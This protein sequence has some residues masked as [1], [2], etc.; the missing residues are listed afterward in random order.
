MNLAVKI[1]NWLYHLKCRYISKYT[2]V[3][4]KSLH[5][6]V[7]QPPCRVMPHIMMQVLSDCVDRI[8]NEELVRIDFWW[9]NIFQPKSKIILDTLFDG[10]TAS[11]KFMRTL[12]KSDALV[13]DLKDNLH[14]LVDHTEDLV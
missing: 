9:K 10:Q 13:R 14:Y 4:A 11:K 2:T 5:D 3:K 12:A 1:S 7:Y 6:D 8:D